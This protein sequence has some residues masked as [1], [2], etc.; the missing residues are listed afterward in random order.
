MLYLGEK[1]KI[2]ILLL[3]LDNKKKVKRFEIKPARTE[4]R[5]RCNN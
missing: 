1:G 3:L 4:I 2:Q 5:K